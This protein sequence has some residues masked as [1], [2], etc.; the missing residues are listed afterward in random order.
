[1]IKKPIIP[2]YQVVDFAHYL[3]ALPRA[4]EILR[5]QSD[6]SLFLSEEEEEELMSEQYVMTREYAKANN[7]DQ[8]T[9]GLSSLGYAFDLLF[10]KNKG[11]INEYSIESLKKI[12]ANFK[13]KDF[14]WEAKP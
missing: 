3:D 14:D 8:S 11:D 12:L 10:C 13:K 1:M 5:I 2:A 6:D 7:L 9:R 4:H